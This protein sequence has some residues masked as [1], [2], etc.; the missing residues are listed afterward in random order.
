MLVGSDTNVSVLNGVA[1]STFDFAPAPGDYKLVATG[2][3][4]RDSA[5]DIALSVTGSAVPE[6]ATRV[7]LLMGALAA[8]AMFVRRRRTI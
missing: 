8:G 1:S 6:P 5:L 7:L 3:G 2:N 4:L